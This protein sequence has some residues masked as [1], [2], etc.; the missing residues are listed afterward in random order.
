MSS[1]YGTVK[2]V[3]M[4][5]LYPRSIEGLFFTNA[6]CRFPYDQMKTEPGAVKK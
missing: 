5:P 6:G 2:E 4:N 3:C 1:F